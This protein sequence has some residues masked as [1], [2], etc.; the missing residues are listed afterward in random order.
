MSKL[1]QYTH[2]VRQNPNSPSVLKQIIEKQNTLIDS[3][4]IDSK[5]GLPSRIALEDLVNNF[6]PKQYP[7]G[8]IITC[9]YLD[10]KGMKFIDDTYGHQVGD[11]YVKECADAFVNCFRTKRE[12]LL[13]H[14]TQTK[15]NRETSLHRPHIDGDEFVAF[16][17]YPTD[18]DMIEPIDYIISQ[19]LER[20]KK[21]VKSYITNNN[22]DFRFGISHHPI[23]N[24][25]E[26]NQVFFAKLINEADHN[27]NLKR[28]QETN[29]NER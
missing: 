23:L 22:I 15:T 20:V 12:D 13:F 1:D 19:R 29:P 6:D 4:M 10:L 11:K 9:V 25:P 21:N 3:L 8:T 5:T 14:L 28:T 18:P 7:E 2:G 27:L 16:I 24:V 17:V 26:S